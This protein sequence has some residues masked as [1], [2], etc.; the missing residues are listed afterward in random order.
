MEREKR[1]REA[2]LRHHIWM[3][4]CRTIIIIP[5]KGCRWEKILVHERSWKERKHERAKKEEEIKGEGKK[6]KRGRKSW[7]RL[8]E[9]SFLWFPSFASKDSWVE[10]REGGHW[11]REWVGGKENRAEIAAA[12][13][14]ELPVIQVI[15]V[16]TMGYATVSQCL[17]SS[18]FDT[19]VHS[20]SPLFLS[21]YLNSHSLPLLSIH[22][23]T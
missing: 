12:V 20:A 14:D 18:S 9:P 2:A 19:S 23:T 7:C 11:T 17:T 8:C 22:S 3:C 5:G 10:N 6:M 1:E 4:S 21:F 15:Q 16:V 13:A